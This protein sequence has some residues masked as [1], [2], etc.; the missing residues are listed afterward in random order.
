[1]PLSQSPFDKFDTACQASGL[2]S[3]LNEL[4]EYFRSQKRYH[5]LFELRKL[6]LRQRLGLTVDRWQSI[7]EMD[8]Q[9]GETF[10][11]ELLKI[12][13][14][15]GTLFFEDADP[16][17]GWHY[18]EPVGDR[19]QVA[20]LLQQMPVTDEN[21]E[22]LIQV[23]VGQALHPEYG[24]QLVL[25]RFGTCSSITAYE[26][27]L[28]GQT[29]EVR[30]GPARMLVDHLYNELM[31]RLREAIEEQEGSPPT[32]TNISQLIETRPW[33]FEGLGHHIDTT[34]LASVVRIAKIVQEDETLQRA[35]QLCQYGMQLHE[36]FQYQGHAPFSNIYPDTL[37]F[38]RALTGS[39]KL[40][41]SDDAR[42]EVEEAIDQAA[43]HLLQQTNTHAES[44]QLDSAFWYVYFLN[45]VGRGRQAVQAYLDF[46]HV[47][48]NQGMASE[49]VCPNLEWLV[50]QHGEFE[51]AKS[52]LLQL[53]DLLS[54]A[55]ISAIQHQQQQK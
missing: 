6:Q 5:E 22:S 12:C 13:R 15:I 42:T 43:D 27:Q 52:G 38:L 18:F 9:V 47:Q 50:S 4:A 11:K 45:R 31:N 33:L 24:F 44:N 23:A 17:S 48:Q 36:D 51:V 29:L 1:M 53:G 14:E 25:D 28:A 40:D 54:Y 39:A 3:G 30:R 34:H 21:V 46:V 16:V 8:Q 32:E 20:S 49:K 19:A 37:L 10:E 35:V 55:A 41:P 2:A 7:D 26:S